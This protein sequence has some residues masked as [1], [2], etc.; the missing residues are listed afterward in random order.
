MNKEIKVL[1]DPDTFINIG[2]QTIPVGQLSLEQAELVAAQHPGRY[3]S[4]VKKNGASTPVD[5]DVQTK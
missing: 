1:C 5:G 2:D 3:V 4:I